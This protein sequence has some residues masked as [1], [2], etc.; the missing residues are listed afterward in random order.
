MSSQP[1]FLSQRALATAP[2]RRSSSQRRARAAAVTIATALAFLTFASSSLASVGSVYY[3]T[4]GNAA[5]GGTL[6]NGTF[7][8]TRQRRARPNVM[9][10]LTSGSDNSAIGAGALVDVTS[11]SDNIANGFQALFD[12]RTGSS[13][14]ASGRFALQFN[15]SG[16]DNVATG[17]NALDIEHNGH[18]QPYPP[19]QTRSSSNVDRPRQRRDGLP[20]DAQQHHRAS[21]N[22]GE[23]GSERALFSNTTGSDNVATGTGALL[24]Q[25][26]RQQQRRERLLARSLNNTTATTTPPWALTPSPRTRQAT[27]TSPSA[28]GRA[29]T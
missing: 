23:T 18:R 21:D 7:T 12:D 17:T 6:F 13:N 10:I 3:D 26:D 16:S 19:A 27:A 25:H 2:L 20:G 22:V 29:R 8:G 28:P 5:A 4:S 14:I 24:R 15:S 11:G 9:P 1:R